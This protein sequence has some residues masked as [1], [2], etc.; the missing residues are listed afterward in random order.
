MI[1]TLILTKKNKGK[2]MKIIKNLLILTIAIFIA[3]PNTFAN[4]AVDA[5]SAENFIKDVTNQA[6]EDII[7]ADITHEEKKNNFEKIFKSALDLKFIARFVLGRNWRTSSKAQQ[8]EFIKTYSEFNIKLWS[9]RF[10][11]F[12]GKK[13]EFVGTKASKSK[14]QIFVNTQVPMENAE[15]AKVIW[16]VK[17]NKKGEYKIIDIIAEGVSLA[18]TARNEYASFIKSNPDGVDALIK[19]LKEKTKNL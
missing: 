18:M 14:N 5:T 11:E 6:I 19:D 3:I 4:R 7:N 10:D 12:T 15:P 2:K 13:F 16:R 1:L 8:E 17:L 9:N